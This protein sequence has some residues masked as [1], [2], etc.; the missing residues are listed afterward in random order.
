MTV[1]ITPDTTAFV[2]GLR[3]ARRAFMTL[4][5]TTAKVNA[6]LERMAVALVNDP[7]Q[8]AG[9][10][11]RMYV[12]GGLDPAYAS[13]ERIQRL[14]SDLLARP[15]KQ[16]GE[17]THRYLTPANRAALA[18][19]A[20]RGWATHRNPTSPDVLAW[21]RWLNGTVLEVTRG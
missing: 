19:H 5:L 12:R 6:A 9:L 2:A 15:W 8:M 1:D 18:A 17:A 16:T 14:V 7:V 21:C 11:G 4:G 13:E 3:K 10:E 20:L